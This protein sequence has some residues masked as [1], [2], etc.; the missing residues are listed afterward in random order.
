MY[1]HD[2]ISGFFFFFFLVLAYCLNFSRLN[3]RGEHQVRKVRFERLFI[4][5]FPARSIHRFFFLLL[6]II[7][8]I[9]ASEQ[10]SSSKTGQIL[11]HRQHWCL[12]REMLLVDGCVAKETTTEPDLCFSGVYEIKATRQTKRWH[13]NNN[14]F[15][16]PFF[17]GK[18]AFSCN[19][20]RCGF[21]ADTF[22]SS[23]ETITQHGWSRRSLLK[24]RLVRVCVYAEEN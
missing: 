10:E 9:E 18:S 8:P 3:L 5:C 23:V 21:V 15:F 12:Y 22:D 19:A 16:F 24:A 20:P 13:G 6:N 4:F 7:H 14:L 11:D 2:A 1:G 17:L